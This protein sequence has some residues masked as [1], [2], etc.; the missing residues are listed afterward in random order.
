MLAIVC[1]SRSR[2]GSAIEN[3]LFGTVPT[4][5]D[6]LCHDEALFRNFLRSEMLWVSGQSYNLHV[7]MVKARRLDLG[8]FN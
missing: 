2:L 4:D 6:P 5:P 3:F 1:S 8:S 7:S